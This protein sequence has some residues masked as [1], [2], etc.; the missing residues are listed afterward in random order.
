M[1]VILLF[2]VMEELS[3]GGG[4]LLDIPC[5]VFERMV[6]CACD[7]SVRLDAPSMSSVNCVQSTFKPLQM[8]KALTEAGW[9]KQKDTHGYLLGSHET[10][11]GVCLFHMVTSCIENCHK[12]HTRHKHTTSA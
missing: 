10:G 4:A 1:V 7:S 8:I 9:G 6:C 3:V 12:M 2:N 5:M 11:S